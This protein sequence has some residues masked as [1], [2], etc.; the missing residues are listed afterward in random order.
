MMKIHELI[1]ELGKLDPN[2]EIY[3]DTRHGGVPITDV[4]IVPMNLFEPLDF[5][6]MKNKIII[7][8]TVKGGDEPKSN[9]EMT[10]IGKDINPTKKN[11]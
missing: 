7:L 2:A 6:Q 11:K 10:I 5:K 1:S 4:K 3:L 9:K 8:K